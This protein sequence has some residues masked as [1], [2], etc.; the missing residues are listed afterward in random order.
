VGDGGSPRTVAVA[1]RGRAGGSFAAALARAGWRVEEVPGRSVP[2][3]IV[4]SADLVLLAVPDGAVA[5]AA[6]SLRPGRAVVA[7]CAG[8]LGLDVLAPHQRVASIHPLVSLSA[9]EVGAER[10]RGAW[11][12]VAGDPE[13]GHALALAV[14][15]ELGGRPVDVPDDRRVAY[16][17]AAAVASNH[18]V[19]LLGQVERLAAAAGVPAE[20]YWD[21]ARPTIDNV[22]E[23]GAAAALTGPVARGDWET[24]RQHLTAIAL[25][26][27]DAY[28]A[29]SAA[30][31]R[32][33]GRDVPD[34]LRVRP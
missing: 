24:V 5:D 25:D 12:A 4:D 10:L 22:V 33:V 23:Q 32:L 34:D 17:A 16:H 2:V 6:R 11:F 18:L 14:V 8:S 29:M 28:L 13:V 9:P 7:H 20:A 19:A 31:A 21:L 15:E 3:G 1:G 27:R 26:E 30:A